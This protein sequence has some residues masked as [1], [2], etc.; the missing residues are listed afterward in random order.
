MSE[1]ADIVIVGAGLAGALLAVLLGKQGARVHL[2]E[3][4]PDPRAAGQ[5]TGRSINL[6]I[7]TRGLYALERAGLETALLE[8]AIPMRGRIIHDERGG[9]TFQPYGA[10]GEAINSVSRAGLNA[11]M[12]GFAPFVCV[13]RSTR[14]S[15]S[16]LAIRV[17]T[18]RSCRDATTSK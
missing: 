14:M 4:R 6:A 12:P 13:E 7:S 5:D 1:R 8:R 9:T 15:R 2:A 11:R 17:A 18:A 10:H 16:S 3:R